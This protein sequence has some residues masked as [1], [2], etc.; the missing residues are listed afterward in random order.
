MLRE[1]V[2]KL[3]ADSPLSDNYKNLWL[4]ALDFMDQGEMGVMKDVLEKLPYADIIE[5]S[6]VLESKVSQYRKQ[7][8]ADW[9]KLLNSDKTN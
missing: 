5:V 7:E 8:E 6:K 9:E 4:E 3:I 2:E 1:T